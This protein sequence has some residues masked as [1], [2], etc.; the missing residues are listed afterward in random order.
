MQK[1]LNSCIHDTCNLT[2]LLPSNS[3]IAHGIGLMLCRIIADQ[4]GTK[5]QPQ[6]RNTSFLI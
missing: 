2:A 4:K 5:S 1:K 3:L 6:K